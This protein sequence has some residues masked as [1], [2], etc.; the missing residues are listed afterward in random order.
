MVNCRWF[1]NSEFGK[2]DSRLFAV[3]S[4]FA[5]IVKS[6]LYT[7][8]D[9]C[10]LCVKMSK[11]SKLC[12]VYRGWFASIRA[13]SY[14]CIVMCTISPQGGIFAHHQKKNSHKSGS[15][16]FGKCTLN[17]LTKKERIANSVYTRVCW[18]FVMRL[19]FV[20]RAHHAYES[21]MTHSV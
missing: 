21:R 17:L 3:L 1:A 11:I 20:N 9:A 12:I 13:W 14:A 18:W 10:E 15:Y 7:M 8:C 16:F 5:Q 6:W 2:S 4:V 19:L